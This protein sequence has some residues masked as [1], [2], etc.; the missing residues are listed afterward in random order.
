MLNEKQFLSK[1]YVDGLIETGKWSSH[2]SDVHRLIEDELLESLPE[3]LQEMDAD[4]SLRHSDFRPILCNWLSARFNKCKKDI[5]EELKSNRDENCLY[6][7][8][9][10]I[11]CNEELI[12]KIKTEDFDIGRFWTVMKYYE[13]IDRNPDNES[14]FEV[15]VEAKVALSD[16]DLVETMR[17]RMDYS[18]GD[19]EAEIYIKNGAQP[20]FMSY[21]VV[22]PDGDYLGEF[23]CDKTKDRYLNFTK[24]ARTPELE[25]SY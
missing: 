18:N 4:D 17:S 12:H 8:T 13:F 5:V 25:A 24:K 19:E 14:L 11:M 9:R 3:H 20:L 15:T 2:G 1:E 23:D 21:A 16:I 22:T 6:S 10:T 7:I